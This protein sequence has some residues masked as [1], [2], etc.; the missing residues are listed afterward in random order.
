LGHLPRKG[1]ALRV[2][3]AEFTVEEI[4][5]RVIEKVRVKKL[6]PPPTAEVEE[7]AS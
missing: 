7:E 3:G 2:N 6:D 4:S 1:E 5:D